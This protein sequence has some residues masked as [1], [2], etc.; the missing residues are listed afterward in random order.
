MRIQLSWV[1]WGGMS[2]FGDDSGQHTITPCSPCWVEFVNNPKIIINMQK[3]FRTA[4]NVVTGILIWR[5]FKEHR[6]I[7]K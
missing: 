5:N 4:Q 7:K 2:S 6:N 3:M 1:G